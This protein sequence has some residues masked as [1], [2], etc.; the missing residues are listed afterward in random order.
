[1][2]L[3]SKSF[4]ALKYY[5]NIVIDNVMKAN[6][7][8]FGILAFIATASSTFAVH[9][10]KTVTYREDRVFIINAPIK[11]ADDFRKLAKQAT[12]L[13]TYGRVQLNISTLADKSFHEIPQQG[14][15][16]HEYASNNPSPFKFFPDSK[17][18]PFLPAEFVKKNRQMLLEKAKILR[19]L[20][21]EAA[22]FGYEPNFL[23]AAFFEAY[24][25]MLGPRV[26]H[27]RRSTE[28]A[29]APCTNVWDVQEMY[30]NM[31]AEMLK[32]TP[33]IS[34]FFFKTNDAGAGICWA[35][36][37]YTGPNGPIK[38][39][40]IT[41]G[42]RVNTLLKTFQDGAAKAGKKLDVFVDEA[43]SNFSDDEKTDIQNHLPANCY[44]ENTAD[45]KMI[46]VGSMVSAN[47]P[48]T[49]IIDPVSF[50]QSARSINDPS[51]KTIFLNFRAS[52]DRGYERTDV[53]DV[54]ID[55]LEYL[56]KQKQT[57]NSFSKEEQLK[58]LCEMWAGKSGADNLYKA[59]TALNDAYTY[60]NSVIPRVSSLYWGVTTRH[61]TRPLVIV[62]SRLSQ[63]E[64]AY[65]LPYVFNVSKD[66]ARNDYTDVHGLHNT[67]P[68]GAVSSF[69]SRLTAAAVMF[70][71][72][73]ASAPK[74]EFL[75]K[76]A[77]S[78]RIHASIIRSCG[79]FAKAQEIRER[80]KEKLAVAAHLPS[81]VPTFTGDPD[82][83]P[84]VDVARDELDNTQELIDLLQKGG[85]DLVI[86]SKDPVY[87]DRFVLG[88]DLIKQLQKKRK[89]MLDHW[90]DIEG[91][92][93]SPFK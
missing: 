18:A 15:P 77:T 70:E 48:V 78:M 10:Q 89:V 30:T 26:D 90:S 34:T 27:P 17:L 16:W 60:K 62:P 1:M 53:T 55:M 43:S 67:I 52:Y 87:E 61:I 71:K 72:I 76:M 91:Y 81:K 63:Q 80:N 46:N 20:G 35:H 92:L 85:I 86:Y 12:R 9:A 44:F 75:S 28:K 3:I 40:D 59:F 36:W 39:R 32:N 31:M 84:F 93:A 2:I 64:E 42:E 45:H 68:E 5:L 47:Y 23:P 79:N 22:F 24:P 4:Y 54:V 82:F 49:G 8:F 56:L 57:E 73:D 25:Q 29:F 50:I 14:S 13:K 58:G 88:P 51:V 83:I 21:L 69:V 7:L 6:H 33:E 41:M 11:N 74:K 65:F 38:C 37:L 66:E 19:E